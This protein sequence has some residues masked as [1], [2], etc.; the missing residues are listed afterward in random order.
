MPEQLAYLQLMRTAAVLSQ[1]IG[2]LVAAHGLSAKQ[3]S[4]LRAA[5]RGGALGL[6][7]G[8]IR[9][10]MT[11]PQAD[12]TRLLDRLARDGHVRRAPDPEDRRV[13]RVALTEAGAALLA[14]VEDPMLRA[15]S[16]QFGHL[17][18]AELD[19]LVELLKKARLKP[20]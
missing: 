10:E 2:A 3:H 19:L 6:T 18:L 16:D 11:D 13:V 5:R 1:E 20:S 15:H 12:V 8:E 14:A 9:A 7:V 4:A 17:S